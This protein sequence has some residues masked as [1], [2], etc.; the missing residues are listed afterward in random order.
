MN[1]WQAMNCG[2]EPGGPQA[3]TGVCPAAT[4]RAGHG[5]HYGVNA[6]RVCWAI[7]G[8]LCGDGQRRDAR[9]KLHD[10][11]RCRFFLKVQS[12]EG[13]GLL[14]IEDIRTIL[15]GSR[16]LAR[17]DAVPVVREQTR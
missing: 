7:D 2:R 11:M 9:A 4:N 12:E 10:C 14:A 5:M 15:Y 6:G 8:T 16:K 3:G 1:C 13:A 17:Q